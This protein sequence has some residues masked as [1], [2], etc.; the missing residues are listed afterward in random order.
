[1]KK[2]LTD[3]EWLSIRVLILGTTVF[4]WSFLTEIPG[5]HELFAD[6][7]KCSF[8][9]SNCKWNWGFRHYCYTITFAILTLI[10]SIR[11]I[12]WFQEKDKNGGFKV[13][14]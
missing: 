12:K 8:S 10:Q 11:I 14:I 13:K 5:A 9:G 7:W 2:L 1:M 4:F 6:T 3:W